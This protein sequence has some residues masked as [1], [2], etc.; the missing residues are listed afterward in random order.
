[1]RPENQ[2]GETQVATGAL[3]AKERDAVAAAT[4][5]IRSGFMAL[6]IV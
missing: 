5:D 6:L 2:A 3:C 4:L 1:M